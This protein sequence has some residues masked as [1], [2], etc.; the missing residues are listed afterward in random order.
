M[1]FINEKKFKEDQLALLMAT[2]CKDNCFLPD[3]VFS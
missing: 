2:Y 1:P 3:R